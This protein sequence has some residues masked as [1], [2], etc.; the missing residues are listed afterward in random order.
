MS[1]P[2]RAGWNAYPSTS[3]FFPYTILYSD[4]FY[5]QNSLNFNLCCNIK[6]N[7]EENTEVILTYSKIP[8]YDT[9][10]TKIEISVFDYQHFSSDENSYMEFAIY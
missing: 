10:N 7:V 1:S 4:A 3:R 2:A 6:E 8:I 5:K 9:C